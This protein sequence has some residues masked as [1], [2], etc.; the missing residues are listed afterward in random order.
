MVLPV[1]E[2]V[3]DTVRSCRIPYCDFSFYELARFNLLEFISK[4]MSTSQA[5]HASQANLSSQARIASN[6]KAGKPGKAIQASTSS[7][8]ARQTSKPE[9]AAKAS[10]EL[11]TPALIANP[12]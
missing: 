8:Q 12:V 5:S 2:K 10:V 11:A 6:I 9:Q 4:A 3:S 7:E 1:R